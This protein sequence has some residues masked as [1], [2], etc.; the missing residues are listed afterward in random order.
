MQ[1]IIGDLGEQ[2]KGAVILAYGIFQPVLPAV[3][4]APGAPIWRVIGTFRGL[5][6]YLLVPL[7][8]YNFAQVWIFRKIWQPKENTGGLA[9]SVPVVPEQANSLFYRKAQL[10]W[11]ALAVWGWIL[12]ASA[13]AGGDQWDNP[14][15]RAMFLVWQAV[16]AAWTWSVVRTNKDRWFWRFAWIE[17]VFVGLFIYWYV[18]RKYV[19]A[20][21]LDIWVIVILFGIASSGII[22][23]GWWQ[24]R[25]Q[26][27]K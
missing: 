21:V 13:N 23:Y 8:V 19:A 18:G 1:N 24:D 5:G 3:L 27:Q 17:A 25:R 14:R 22:L 9:G 11:L 7:L 6:W 15:Y 26:K 10:R 4:I 12:I 16:L 20:L 2:W